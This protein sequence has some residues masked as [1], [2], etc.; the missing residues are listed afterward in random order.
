MDTFEQL[1]QAP[2]I[3][4]EVAS[5]LIRTDGGTQ[6]RSHIDPLTV[7]DYAQSMD[8]GV[9]FPPIETVFDGEHHWVYD[10][11][12]RLEAMIRLGKPTIAVR[13]IDGDQAAAQLLALTVNAQHG[14]PRDSAT[15]RRQVEAAL[16]MEHLTGKSDRDIAKLCNVS[17]PFVAAVRNPLTKAKQDK[18]RE[19]SASKKVVESDST[20][21]SGDAE[22]HAQVESDSTV[23]PGD[24]VP[25][26]KVESDSTLP[27]DQD[28]GPDEDELKAMELAEQADRQMFIKLL[29][30]D[31]AFAVAH[32]E[33]ERL[34]YLVAQF[35]IRIASLMNEKN[36]AVKQAQD[37][38][39]KCK[40]LESRLRG[41]ERPPA[42]IKLDAE[43][44]ER[45]NVLETYRESLNCYDDE[46][47]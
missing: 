2:R 14:L 22:P 19:A 16:N 26:D 47:F 27:L 8:D 21:I 17:H 23:R 29:E 1:N 40:K 38:Q 12:H 41:Y 43:V 24:L 45:S 34:N 36:A 9:V 39:R 37:A 4:A 18:N 33:V 31:D 35:Q 46:A 5:T 25:N 30:S 3:N 32:K 20:L 7:R 6:Y 11:F 15:K 42:E 44:R 13:Y 28:Y 10:G